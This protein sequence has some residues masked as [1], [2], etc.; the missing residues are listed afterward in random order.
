M[1]HLLSTSSWYLENIRY[2]SD[3]FEIIMIYTY[4]LLHIQAYHI[5]II[6]IYVFHENLSIFSQVRAGTGE[7]QKNRI[8]EYFSTIREHVKR[9]NY[10]Y[11]LLEY[12]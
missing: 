3:I 1:K 6:K 2:I 4:V 8:H 11:I 5:N 7:R 10:I 12:I 9:N